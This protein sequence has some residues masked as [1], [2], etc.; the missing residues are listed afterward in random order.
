MSRCGNFAGSSALPRSIGRMLKVNNLIKKKFLDYVVKSGPTNN[1]SKTK[2][3]TWTIA[4]QTWID[5]KWKVFCSISFNVNY[6]QK[7]QRTTT[8]IKRP[9]STPLTQRKIAEFVWQQLVQTS[10]KFAPLLVLPIERKGF[11]YGRK[12]GS[13]RCPMDICTKLTPPLT[14]T[15]NKINSQCPFEHEFQENEDA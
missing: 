12:N 13:A 3:T 11:F 7:E 14:R 1:P 4:F 5:I 6:L 8:D 10:S 15:R 9:N 2:K